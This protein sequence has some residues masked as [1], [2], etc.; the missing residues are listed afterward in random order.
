L[1]HNI[2]SII[3]SNANAYMH[4]GERIRCS[5]IKQKKQP[6]VRKLTSQ[7][8]PPQSP[9][10]VAA[11]EN[12]DYVRYKRAKSEKIQAANSDKASIVR[13][14]LICLRMAAW[15]LRIRKATKLAR[16]HLKGAQGMR[17]VLANVNNIG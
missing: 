11:I 1:L 8:L 3:C 4:K 9:K 14:I 13:D 7:R 15:R 6:S 5:G 16:C 12:R 2:F 10:G 17:R